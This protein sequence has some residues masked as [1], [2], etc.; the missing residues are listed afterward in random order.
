MKNFAIYFKIKHFFLILIKSC[1][2]QALWITQ[3]PMMWL[4]ATLYVILF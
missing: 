4:N 3:A 2:S 1:N